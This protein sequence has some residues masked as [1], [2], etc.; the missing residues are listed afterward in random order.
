[1]VSRIRFVGVWRV[2][3][4]DRFFGVLILSLGCALPLH[5]KDG[6]APT[7][8]G[9]KKAG[10][11]FVI[12]GEYEGKLGE[13]ARWGAHV[14][15]TGKG[16]F[17]TVGYVGGLPGNG[18]TGAT[19]PA[20]KGKLDGKTVQMQGDNFRLLI[21]GQT[22]KVL[23][24]EGD[25]LGTLTKVKRKSKTLGKKP[26]KGAIVLFDG[27]SIDKWNDA[28]LVQKRLLGATNCFT[29]RKFGDHELHIEFRTPF[30]PQSTGQ[31][32]GN[33]GVYVQSRYEVQVLDSFGLEGKDN[34][35][36]GIYKVSKPEPHMCYPPLSWQT[37]DIDFT[38][39]RYDAAGK[40]TK[41]A[42]ITVRHNDVVIHD[43][44]ELPSHTPGRRKE[45]PSSE[46][47]FLQNHGNPVMYRNIWVIEK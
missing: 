17:R 45:G 38:A 42:R 9:A 19:G 21:D 46:P 24:T 39:A 28:K 33:S 8:L 5:A 25:S 15:A 26:P 43:D 3:M 35:C 10:I 34:E 41:N 7:Y 37:Y 47:L 32:R 13:S 14:I 44:L 29:K 1:M 31:A 30:M 23:S 6:A 40:K 11:D 18:W 20:L 2:G 36:G 22:L 12:Q 4:C 16:T 27:K